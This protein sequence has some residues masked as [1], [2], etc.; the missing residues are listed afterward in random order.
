ME[1]GVVSDGG[2]VQR[3]AVPAKGRAAALQ[4]AWAR[5]VLARAILLNF[6]GAAGFRAALDHA[7]VIERLLFVGPSVLDLALLPAELGARCCVGMVTLH[8]LEAVPHAVEA[9]DLA[10]GGL[11]AEK[12]LPPPWDDAPAAA[13]GTCV[14]ARQ[15]TCVVYSVKPRVLAEHLVT[16]LDRLAIDVLESVQLADLAMSESHV[17]SILEAFY[18]GLLAV[19]HPVDLAS[20]AMGAAPVANHV[21]AG[22]RLV[23]VAV[24]VDLHSSCREGPVY[25]LFIGA[26][27]AFEEPRR[28]RRGR[29]L[30]QY[31]ALGLVGS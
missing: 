8:R 7:Q 29:W 15:L 12:L 31:Q 1:G 17:A 25:G 24:D 18:D 30:V 3:K 21:I 13:A 19:Y 23:N 22:V 28:Q 6:D 20:R 27:G 16:Q 2:V 9:E 5:H 26:H 14:E 10:A 4:I 11:A